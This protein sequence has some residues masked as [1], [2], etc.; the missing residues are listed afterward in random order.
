MWWSSLHPASPGAARLRGAARILLAAMI[1]ALAG[2][3]F[4]L[5]GAATYHFDSIYVNA[6]GAGAFGADLRK[7]LENASTA[8][9][10]DDPTK[11]QVILD[12]TLVVDDKDVLSLSPGGR[13]REFAL[14]K[15]VQIRLHDIAGNDWLPSDEIIIRRT[16]LYD[17]TERLARQIEENRLVQEMQ[18]DAV[19]QIVRR[20]QAA[21]KPA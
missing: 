2:C 11:A 3:G 9:L 12:I 7:A 17:D 4:H 20:L 14:Q 18:A 6:P 13:A 16:Y 5:R 1:V 10:V 19:Q 8:K 15:R 21:R